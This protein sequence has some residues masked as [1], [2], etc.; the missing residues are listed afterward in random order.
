MEWNEPI[1][2]EGSRTGVLVIHGFTGS[3]RSMHEYS[4]RFAAAG[5]TVSLPLL[6]GHGQT[7]EEMGKARWTD[8]TADVEKAYQWLQPRTD[9]IFATGL[10]MGGTLALWLAEQRSEMAG[11]IPVNAALRYSQELLMK[12]AGSIGIPRWVKGVGNDIKKAGEDERVFSKIPVR[13]TRQFALLLAATRAG[14]ERIR[15]PALIFSSKED[16]TVPPAN[17]EELFRSLRCEEKKLVVL[18]NS[19]HVVTMDHDKELVFRE[20]LGFVRAHAG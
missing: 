14:L 10:S 20:A 9:R 3:P 15:C 6:T 12:L 19:Y 5:Y 16:H 1:Y 7:P 8:W 17:Q 4:E 13:A 18:E 2:R 11:I